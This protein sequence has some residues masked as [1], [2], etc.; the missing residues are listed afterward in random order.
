MSGSKG[1]F[2]RIVTK[3]KH[4]KK[5]KSRNNLKVKLRKESEITDGQD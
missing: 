5:K 2:D 3:I 1:T 4:L